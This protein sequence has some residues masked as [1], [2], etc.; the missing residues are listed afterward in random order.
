MKKKKKKKKKKGKMD[1][2]DKNKLINDILTKDYK[3]VIDENLET[4]LNNNEDNALD[5]VTTKMIEDYYW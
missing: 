5:D 4:K 1:S 2:Q 3:E